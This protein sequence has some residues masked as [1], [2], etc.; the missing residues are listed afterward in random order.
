MSESIFPCIPPPQQIYFVFNCP[1]RHC[2]ALLIARA[3]FF[4]LYPI[5]EVMVKG[6]AGR[7][8]SRGRSG[9][10]AIST[11]EHKKKQANSTAGEKRESSETI[12]KWFPSTT[13]GH[14][15]EAL[16]AERSPPPRGVLRWRLP[17][18]KVVPV[19]AGEEHILH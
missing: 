16:V 12:G 9:P 6:E 5:P 1:Q 2:H 17:G 19:P 4:L 10:Q 14:H 13:L 11:D 3:L 18:T 7:G 15:L 8:W